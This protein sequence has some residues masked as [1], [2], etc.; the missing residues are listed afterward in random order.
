MPKYTHK[1]QEQNMSDTF[2]RAVQTQHA[3]HKYN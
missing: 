3:Q 2:I 1:H